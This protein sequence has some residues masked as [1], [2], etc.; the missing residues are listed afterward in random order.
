V[1]ARDFTYRGDWTGRL[2]SEIRTIIRICFIDVRKE[3]VEAWAAIIEARK[4]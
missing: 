2:F 4:D 3:L 1:A